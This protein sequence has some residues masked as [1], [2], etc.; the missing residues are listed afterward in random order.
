MNT[1]N[2]RHSAKTITTLA[3]LAGTLLCLTPSANAATSYLQELEAE[4]ARTTDDDDQAPSPKQEEEQK[5]AS[6]QQQLH[7][8]HIKAG[9]DKTQF[10]EQ[11][12]KN[13]YGSYLFYSTLTAEKQ[14]SVYNDYQSANDIESIRNSIKS[15]LKD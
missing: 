8:E 1:E 6:D 9:L 10:E 3:V 13:F 5:W 2:R 15:R 7:A 4:A 14:Q 11:L 12:E